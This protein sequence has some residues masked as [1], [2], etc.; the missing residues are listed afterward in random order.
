MKVS[1][2][3]THGTPFS[4]TLLT[5]NHSLKQLPTKKRSKSFNDPNVVFVGNMN[6]NVT[7]SRFYHW[8]CS[9]SRAD[10]I[11]SY[12]VMYKAGC[13]Q[14][15]ATHMGYGFITFRDTI[16]AA[17]ALTFLDGATLDG[18]KVRVRRAFKKEKEG[19]AERVGKKL[20]W[21]VEGRDETAEKDGG[22]A[23]EKLLTEFKLP[24]ESAK[25]AEK[26]PVGADFRE[27]VA[28]RDSIGMHP[29]R[30]SPLAT[31]EKGITESLFGGFGQYMKKSV[32][33]DSVDDSSSDTS[34]YAAEAV[35]D[36][37]EDDDEDRLLSE[38]DIEDMA[39]EDLKKELRDL[40]LKDTGSK[41]VL[42]LRLRYGLREH[43][44]TEFGQ[45]GVKK[46]FVLEDAGAVA[47]A[48]NSDNVMD[49]GDFII[50]DE[51]I[52]NMSIEDLKTELRYL[53][54]KYSGSKRNLGLRLKEWLRENFGMKF[55]QEG[56]GAGE[57]VAAA[58]SVADDADDSD[59]MDDED[60]M[61][62][63]EDIKSM[64]VEDLKTELR[65]LG[66]KITGN[67]KLLGERLK[68]GLREHFGSEFDGEEK[69][70]GESVPENAEEEDEGVDADESDDD[71]WDGTEDPVARKKFLNALGLLEEDAEAPD[72]ESRAAQLKALGITEEDLI[73]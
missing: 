32:E 24:Q 25:V 60:F 9:H 51:D 56:E 23:F 1:R 55:D 16:D 3:G 38:K 37:G 35:A 41:R 61:I 46:E 63:D 27:P 2:G 19:D 22:A 68:E 21:K 72:P 6:Y 69:E 50:T 12:K 66:L 4:S 58:E 30:A 40:G 33:D 48:D 52:E 13:V 62:T 45:E 14:S 8:I 5:L 42:R 29:Q 31:E 17:S 67:K 36:V 71:D 20:K 39:Q 59:G 73:F 26:L 11:V 65:D 10:R 44:G 57:V 49:D 7:N 70:E 34:S 43:F 54:L 18:K 53:G 28:I 15:N 64:T 47:G